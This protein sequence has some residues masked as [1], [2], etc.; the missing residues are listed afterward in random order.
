MVS[1][2][3]DRPP[4]LDNDGLAGFIAEDI[5][6]GQGFSLD[7]LVHQSSSLQSLHGLLHAG[8]PTE[9]PGQ[10]TAR[11][12]GCSA[13]AGTFLIDRILREMEQC[14]HQ[15][16]GVYPVHQNRLPEAK[17]RH[18][19]VTVFAGGRPL[20]VKSRDTGHPRWNTDDPVGRQVSELV[21]GPSQKVP[22]VLCPP[23]KAATSKIHIKNLLF[24][25]I[26]V[27]WTCNYF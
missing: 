6:G 21:V 7:G 11:M 15:A 18:T 4:W 24:S 25:H 27:Q 14:P 1:R 20:P 12:D 3:M 17:H 13:R 16:S 22:S 9:Q 23:G 8:A 19:G 26:V 2:W 10:Q 5:V